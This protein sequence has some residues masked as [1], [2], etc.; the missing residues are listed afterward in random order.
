M[1]ARKE[2][3]MKYEQALKREARNMAKQFLGCSIPDVKI[4]EITE[5]GFKAIVTARN[6]VLYSMVVNYRGEMKNI[7]FDEMEATDGKV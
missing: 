4:T 6:G 1:A 3:G 5:T 2:A 7:E